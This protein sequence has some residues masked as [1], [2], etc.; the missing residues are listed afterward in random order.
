MIMEEEEEEG[1]E[2]KKKKKKKKR[3]S[4]ALRCAPSD[5]AFQLSSR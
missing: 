2:R 3:P 5:D 4:G 1:G